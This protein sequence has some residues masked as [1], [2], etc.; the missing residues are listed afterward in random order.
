MA[1]LTVEVEEEDIGLMV[2]GDTRGWT[3]GFKVVEEE[4]EE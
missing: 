1:G 3:Q 4:E 2:N